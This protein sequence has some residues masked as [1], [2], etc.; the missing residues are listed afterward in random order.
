MRR[1]PAAD[2]GADDRVHVVFLFRSVFFCFSMGNA[3]KC[4]GVLYHTFS[5]TV[6]LFGN[7]A[8]RFFLSFVR[9]GQLFRVLFNVLCI[10][11]V[12]AVKLSQVGSNER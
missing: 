4:V 5:L 1:V 7:F 9:Q 8:C 12:K 11:I 2:I 6:V 3:L 10:V